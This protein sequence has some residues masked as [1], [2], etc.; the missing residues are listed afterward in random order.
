MTLRHLKSLE[1][2]SLDLQDLEY[3]GLAQLLKRNDWFNLKHVV[4]FNGYGPS[5]VVLDSAKPCMFLRDY[6]RA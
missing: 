4:S 3:Q 2:F 6:P 5:E 1:V